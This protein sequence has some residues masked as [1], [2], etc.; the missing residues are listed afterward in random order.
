MSQTLFYLIIKS[1][2][3]KQG[4]IP[5]CVLEMGRLG[6]NEV[7]CFAHIDITEWKQQDV[8]TDPL[9]TSLKLF[10]SA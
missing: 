7:K 8:N 9:I 6:L 3:K 5:V 4:A 10:S 2:L 1:S